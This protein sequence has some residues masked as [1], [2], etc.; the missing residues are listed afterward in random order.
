MTVPARTTLSAVAVDTQSLALADDE[1]AIARA[2]ERRRAAVA[3]R[4]GDLGAAVVLIGAGDPLH[5][6][7]RDDLTYRFRAHS[8]YF[9]LTDRE[10]SGGVLA[11]TADDGW[12]DFVRPVSTAER[13]WEGASPGAYRGRPVAELEAWLAERAGRPLVLLGT[14][15]AGLHG[16][17]SLADSLRR[18]LHHVR[19]PKDEVELA[20][21]RLAARATGAG[22]ARLAYLIAAGRSERELQI[23]LE[24]EF[25]RHGGDALSFDTIV[26]SGPNSAVLHFPPTGRRLNEGELVLVDAGCEYRGYASD[27]TRTYAVSGGLS[28]EQAAVYEIVRRAL[29]TGIEQCRAG[30]ESRALHLAAA[31]V[32]A[33]GLIEFGVLRGRVDSL[34]EAGAVARFFPHGVGHLVGLGTRDASALPPGYEP[35]PSIPGLRNNLPL[36]AGYVTTVEPGVYFVPALLADPDAR[37][38]LGDAVD[39]DRVES[40]M[41]F[42]GIRLEHNVLITDGAPEVL[43]VDIPLL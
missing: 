25:Y 43:T 17:P 40:L 38:E 11:F 18:G 42:G 36:L 22:F 41:G 6:P 7:G 34:I 4:W 3:E 19:R 5:I 27:V 28:S 23:E 24:A 16:D 32:I 20:R 15:L 30:V 9:Y 35:D 2:V 21:M 29:E 10:R 8:D 31:A 12:V 39:W 1:A 14:P 26:A 37:A 13:L 33:E